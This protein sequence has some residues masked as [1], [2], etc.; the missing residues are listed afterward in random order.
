MPLDTSNEAGGTSLY[1]PNDKF[2]NNITD[3]TLMYDYF[4]ENEFEFIKKTK[5]IQNSTLIFPATIDSFH[6]KPQKF[7]DFRQD[8]FTLQVNYYKYTKKGV[9]KNF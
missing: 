3:G 7:E 2:R 9:V 1:K 6:G 5:F 4:N 8:R